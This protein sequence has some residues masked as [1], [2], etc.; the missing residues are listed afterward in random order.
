MKALDVVY[1]VL[2]V[3]IAGAVCFDIYFDSDKDE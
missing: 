1:I 2:F 3:I